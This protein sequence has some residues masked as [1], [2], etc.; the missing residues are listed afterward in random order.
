MLK[1]DYDIWSLRSSVLFRIRYR[2][3]WRQ[4]LPVHD[5]TSPRVLVYCSS[6]R[7]LGS[8]QGYIRERT[9]KLVQL[10]INVQE[11]TAVNHTRVL[12][13]VELECHREIVVSTSK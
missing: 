11:Q 8:V 10:T 1:F 5:Y 2:A 4:Y 9:V 6:F 7:K 3:K 13:M 12:A